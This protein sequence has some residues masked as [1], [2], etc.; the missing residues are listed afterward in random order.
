MTAE[1]LR[2]AFFKRL[3][4]I[5]VWRSGGKRAPH[6]PLVILYALGRV[7]R[8]ESRLLEFSEAVEPL[9]T[10]LAEFGPPRR[11]H[12]PEYPFWRLERDGFWDVAWPG[13]L[14]VREGRRVDPSRAQLIDAGVA[15]GFSKE[16]QA[17]LETDPNVLR[18][19]ATLILR[20]HFPASLHDEILTAVGLDPDRAGSLSQARDPAFR[21]RVLLSWEYRCAV[22]DFDLRLGHASVGLDAAH[23]RWKQVN[24]PDVPNNGLAL[25]ATHHRLFDRGAFTLVTDA[26]TASG[27]GVVLVASRHAMGGRALDDWLLRYHGSGIRAPQH[28]D[29]RPAP[30]H[31]AWH[32]QEVFREPGRPYHPQT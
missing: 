15:A 20:E 26:S 8:G 29:E 28:P 19:A 24:G 4:E 30:E 12:H 7:A 25:C 5:K 11:H 14:Q 31:M 13:A 9:E 16:V 10:L 17:L 32:R 21:E 22:C 6:K 3:Q 2:A 18:K 27:S 23:I 1:V